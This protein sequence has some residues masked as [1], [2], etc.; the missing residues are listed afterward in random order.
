MSTATAPDAQSIVNQFS[1]D[2][3]RRLQDLAASETAVPSDLRDVISNATTTLFSTRHAEFEHAYQ[4]ARIA[5]I[6][7][8]NL[9]KA[10]A[11]RALRKR[12]ND[13]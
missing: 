10:D 11:S 7:R 6:D 5:S 2:F 1:Q 13:R 8:I 9:N 4:Q 12:V 3:A